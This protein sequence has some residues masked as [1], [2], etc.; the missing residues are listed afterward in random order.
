[1]TVGVGNSGGGVLERDETGVPRPRALDLYV[2]TIFTAGAACLGIA[3]VTRPLN[4]DPLPILAGLIFAGFIAEFFPIRFPMGHQQIEI[5]MS[6]TFGLVVLFLYGLP[7]SLIVQGSL[8]LFGEIR[9][10]KPFKKLIYNIGQVWLSFTAGNAFGEFLYGDRLDQAPA[11]YGSDY[12]AGA[13]GAVVGFLLA[14]ATLNLFVRYFAGVGR[15]KSLAATS[16]TAEFFF[17]ISMGLIAVL[18]VAVF[19]ESWTLALILLLPFAGMYK[20]LMVLGDNVSLAS[21]REAAIVERLESEERHNL[22]RQAMLEELSSKQQH[23][24]LV[25]SQMPAILWTCDRELRPTSN[26]GKGLELLGA[27][28]VSFVGR[29]LFEYFD[30]DDPTFEPIRVH[31]SALEGESGSYEMEWDGRLWV[32]FVEPLTDHM[33]QVVG[34]VALST[35]STDRRRAELQTREAKKLQAIGELAGGVAHDFNNILAVIRNYADF[36]MESS[37]QPEIR[38]DLA[39]VIKASDKGANL[40]RQLLSFSRRGDAQPQIVDINEL[41]SDMLGLVRGALTES[42][43]L[44]V[45]LAPGLPAVEVDPGRIEQVVMNLV[46]NARDAMESGGDLKIETSTVFLTEDDVLRYEIPPGLYVEIAISDEGMGIPQADRERIFE[47]FFTTKARGS[48]TGLGLATVHGI[49][50]QAGGRVVVE[51]E[52]GAGASFRVYLPTVEGS[53][54]KPIPSVEEEAG[55]TTRSGEGFTVLIAEDEPAI[56]LLA[57]RILERE[58]YAVTVASTPQAALTS[59]EGGSVPDLLL[60]DVVMPQMSGRDLADRVK[61]DHPEVKVAFMSGYADAVLGPDDEEGGPRFLA[62]PFTASELVAWVE[63]ALGSRSSVT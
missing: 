44:D 34:T 50:H 60:T 9:G 2:A 26:K 48:G 29:T 56:A 40:V 19:D 23:L 54:G 22:E 52:P 46:V 13:I 6:S 24:D 58:G 7:I 39:Q 42:I 53:T 37:Q 33:G 28:E 35:D 17:E 51:S 55:G 62:K 10:R 8:W 47:P 57:Q 63:K 11:V 45:A 38:S 4:I 3:I 59:I 5:S 21:Q 16:Y 32:T 43:A 41:I 18:A 30:T 12:L 61:G 1:M 20:A 15:L 31:L 25:T 49:V 14:N 36:A 27:E